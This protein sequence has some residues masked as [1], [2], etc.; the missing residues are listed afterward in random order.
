MDLDTIRFLRSDAGRSAISGVPAE[1]V[2]DDRLLG[3]LTDLRRRF[4]PGLAA[5]VVEIVRLRASGRAKFERADQMLFDRAGL[6]QATSEPVARH[7]AERFARCGPD[8]IL[9][10]GCGVG[11]DSIALASVSPV[12]G[13]DRDPA[14]VAM[15]A[16]NVGAYGGIFH[17]VVGDATTP[18]WARSP[19]AVL[20][21]PARRV[22][23]RR[24]FDPGSFQP[25]LGIAVD[26]AREARVG[27]VKT[28]PGIDRSFL[29]TTAEAEFVSLGGELKECVLWF[30]EGR[31]PVAT[32]ASLVG[33]GRFAPGG[34]PAA[35][36]VA[37]PGAVIFEPDPAIIRAGLV[38]HLAAEIGARMIDERI[39]YLTLDRVPDSPFGRP[40]E[41]ESVMP[42][43]LKPLR[44]RLRSLGVGSVTIK[45]RGSPIE[46]E[47][48]RRML[49]LDG[50]EHRVLILTRIGTDPVVIIGAEI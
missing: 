34:D 8:L 15:A 42:F 31:S 1:S 43:S 45:K 14:R 9:D 49:R 6:E 38:R 28:A 20:L 4:E 17:G 3:K 37:A 18:C 21:D 32:S 46:P 41:V 11:G 39:A 26:I 33:V 35:V 25:A 24:T 22:D 44:A 29:P 5:A 13:L 2:E 50:S 16:H 27:A 36:V 19:D 40:Y 12:V 47:D 48:L 10:I 23:R 7:R 30:G